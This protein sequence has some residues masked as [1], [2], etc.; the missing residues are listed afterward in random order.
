MVGIE[1]PPI[2]KLDYIY[3]SYLGRVF[4]NPR[5]FEMDI[6]NRPPA[7]SEDTLQ[8]VLY[9]PPGNP[10]KI[11]VTTFAACIQTLIDSLLPN[12][13]WH[14]DSFELKVVH[15]PDSESEGWM[16]QG[17]MRVGDCVDDEWCVVWLLREVS[18]KWDF[19]IQ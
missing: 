6:F 12:F 3:L 9:P 13:L 19:V 14:R 2:R 15:D 7:I 4:H 17:R 18:R 10:D 5:T 11:A 16:L 1:K 8:Y